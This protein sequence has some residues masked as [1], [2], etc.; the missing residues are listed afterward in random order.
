[1]S[2]QIPLR[3]P[4]ELRR[5]L[6][7]WIRGQVEGARMR[8]VIFGL[9][10]GVDSAV[11]CGLA[12]EALGPERCLGVVMPADS[13][14]DD[15]RLAH[16]VARTYGVKAIE[17]DLSAPAAAMRALL[18]AH[19]DEAR[20][21]AHGAGTGMTDTSPAGSA[22]QEKLAQANLK[23]RLRM[24]TLYYYANLL[25]YL[26]VGTGNKAEFTLGYFTKWG[27]GAADMFVLADLLKHEVWELA[28]E[29]G[30]PAAVVE[31]APSAGLWSGQTDEDEMGLRYVQID[32]YLATGTSGDPAADAEI[33]RRHRNSRHKVAT[34]PT[35]K[36]D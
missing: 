20:T 23:P 27:D 4:A 21:A 26:V 30:V 9:S 8:G 36:L 2:E 13:I 11:V 18:H 12:A 7:E 22:P 6:V 25:D 14:P 16:E 1:M 19:A 28:R 29:I 32:R 33:E 5:R 35:A 34:P 17:V 15:A 10:G 24:I 31:R 3:D